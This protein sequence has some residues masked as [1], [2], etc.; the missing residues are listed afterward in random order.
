MPFFPYNSRRLV[1]F[2]RG[3]NWVQVWLNGL[4][5]SSSW[6]VA[7]LEGSD[8]GHLP[9]GTGQN[10]SE[11]RPQVSWSPSPKYLPLDH[12]VFCPSAYYSKFWFLHIFTDGLKFVLGVSGYP[13]GFPH[14]PWFPG[15]SS[16]RIQG[17]PQDERR[18]RVRE[19]ERDQTGVCSR[20]WQ[21]FI[22]YHSFY[23]LS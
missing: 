4:P 2:D 10:W 7:E 20:V 1:F 13:W 18:R 23:I 9:M 15:S 5:V 3:G 14:C 6:L 11:Q 21:C 8:S 16:S 22:F 12:K 19:R 17:N